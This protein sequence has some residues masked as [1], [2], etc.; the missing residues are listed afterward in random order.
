MSGHL[1]TSAALVLPFAL[2]VASPGT[3]TAWSFDFAQTGPAAGET[4]P[5]SFVC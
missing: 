3:L 4:H 1:R 2:A 5:E